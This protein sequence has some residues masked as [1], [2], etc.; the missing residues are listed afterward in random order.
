MNKAKVLAK[1]LKKD[2]KEHEIMRDYTTMKIGGVADYF[3][4]ANTIDDLIKG[5]TAAKKAELPYF[6]IGAGSNIIF[7]DYGFP[8][9]VI[10]NSTSNVAFL[11]EQSQA[12]VDSGA[13]LS[14]LILSATSSNLSGL[15]FLFGVPGTVGGALYGNAGA[16]AQSIGDYVK[17]ATVLS[18][19][20][21]DEEPEITQL[22]HDWFEFGYRKSK[23][24]EMTGLQ[25]P[26]ILTVKLQLAQNRQEEIMR[27]LNLF[28][29]KRQKTQPVGQSAGC[30]FRN[31]LI[32]EL[33]SVAGKGSIGMPEIPA[34]RTAGFMLDR[35]G[36]KRLKIG[37]VRVSPKHA[38]FILNTNSAKAQEARQIIEDMRFVVQKKF[39]V[40]LEEEIE[41]IGQW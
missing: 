27:R 18:P 30:V 6:I 12:I 34:E 11:S 33:K 9:L 31:P 39:A 38:N 7:S 37:G 21:K 28:K 1:I 41:Y 32:D 15:E 23:L 36:A 17:F 19:G 29:Q 20:K 40:N 3:Y 8:G 22:D 25:K 4:E 10:K 2:L 16:Y 14:K 24:K 13:S 5:V 26:V 35:A